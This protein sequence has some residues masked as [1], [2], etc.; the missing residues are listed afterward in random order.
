MASIFDDDFESTPSAP[1][2]KPAVTPK[3]APTDFFTADTKAKAK[4][5]AEV[6]KAATQATVDI[7]AKHGKATFDQVKAKAETIKLPSIPKPP[8]KWVAAG[9]VLLTVAI[10][11]GWWFT[12]APAS[13]PHSTPVTVASSTPA[14]S[15]SVKAPAP[16]IPVTPAPSPAPATPVVAAP[17]PVVPPPPAVTAA[18]PVPAPAQAPIKSPSAA[19]ISA[20]WSK[21]AKPVHAAS[22]PSP[23]VKPQYEQDADAALNA[24]QKTH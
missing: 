20:Q 10:G 22:K 12:H 13:K 23:A 21:N 6:A 9:G 11:A 19:D 5:A 14:A 8:M 24:W 1:A 4:E 2:P 7:V 18:V 15:A 17:V 3:E 16:A